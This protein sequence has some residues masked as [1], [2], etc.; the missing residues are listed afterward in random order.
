MEQILWTIFFSPLLSFLILILIFKPFFAKMDRLSSLVSIFAISL[1]TLLSILVLL[2][3]SINQR[4]ISF[5][6]NEFLVIGSLNFGI[7][8]ILD[9]L[10]AVMLVVVT[11]VSLLVQIFSVG[12]MSQDKGYIRY[13]AIL[14]LFTTAM[15]GLVLASNI[16]QLFVFWELVGL[17]SYL[18]IGFWHHKPAAVSAAK[19]AFIITR[20]GDFGLLLAI[21]YLFVQ[22]SIFIEN[23]LNPIMIQD[24]IFAVNQGYLSDFFVTLFALGLFA[25]AIGKSAQFPLHT[26]LPDAMEGPTPVSALIHAAT[27]VA[28]G[29]FLVGR[30]FPVFENSVIAMNTLAITGGVT[31]MLAALI[32]LSMNDIK[33]V[34]AYS[35]ISQLGYMMLALGMGALSASIFHLFTHAFFKA[36]LFLGAGSISHS[37]GTFDMNKMGGLRKIM[38]WTYVTFIIGSLSLLGIFPLSGFWSKDEILSGAWSNSGIVSNIAF[39]LAFITI[40]I[41][42]FYM[43]RAIYMTFHGEFKGEISKKDLHESPSVMLIPLVILSIASVFIGFIVNPIISIGFIPSHWFSDFIGHGAVKSHVN[44]FSNW[45]VYGA[46]L[47]SLLAILLA[48]QIYILKNLLLIKFIDK[49][50][51]FRKILINKYYLD[52]FYEEII[53]KKVFLNSLAK[54]LNWFDTNIVDRVFGAIGWIGLNMGVLLRQIQNGQLQTYGS[55][56]SLGIILIMIF[57]MF[58]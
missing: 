40:F 55:I 24:I 18:L 30:F 2:D 38:P 53:V 10:T 31:A 11:S 3:L 51:I 4:V 46:T 50:T 25:G 32:A 26:W 29:V 22:K 6:P 19:K 45:F 16:I 49:F 1:S 52:Y 54:G 39:Y 41:T 9:E 48:Y 57:F 47:I 44:I 15:L 27:M 8:F 17:S 43:F 42:S 21:L 35:T 5:N 20:I 58:L 33:K 14:S 7:S 23:S 34:L 12:Y 36:L 56:V 28:A 13:F 37:T